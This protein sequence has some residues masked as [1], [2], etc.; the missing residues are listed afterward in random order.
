MSVRTTEQEREHKRA[1][2]A[3]RRAEQTEQTARPIHAV[4]QLDEQPSDAELVFADMMGIRSVKVPAAG[5]Y[6]LMVK[7]ELAELG[8]LA[9]RMAGQAGNAVA[10]ARILDNPAA[11][12]Q[13]TAAAG[14][15]R[16][17]LAALQDAA[18][19]S[20]SKSNSVRMLRSKYVG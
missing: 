7:A 15:L 18:K 3:R 1:Q 11:I 6:E 20:R 17:Q 16:A 19:L 10:M 12:L 2:R 4:P 5:E 9:D 14:Q 8:D 13:H